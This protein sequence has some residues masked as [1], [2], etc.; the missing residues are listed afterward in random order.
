TEKRA[1]AQVLWYVPRVLAA[2]VGRKNAR[3]GAALLIDSVQSRRPNLSL[4]LAL[5]DAVVVAVFPE[6]KYQMDNFT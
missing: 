3:D 1:R 2:M 5:F 4:A 6:I